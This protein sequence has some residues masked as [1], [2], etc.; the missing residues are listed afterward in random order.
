VSDPAT[1]ERNAKATLFLKLT[2]LHADLRAAARAEAPDQGNRM[3]TNEATTSWVTVE[4]RNR[5][6]KW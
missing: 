3:P 6:S 5:T 2:S 4:L 1:L